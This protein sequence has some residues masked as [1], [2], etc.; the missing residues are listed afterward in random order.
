MEVSQVVVVDDVLSAEAVKLLRE[1]LATHTV[2]YE[3][4]M[5]ER[6]GGYARTTRILC[7]LFGVF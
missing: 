7:L 1:L 5:P 3:T 4:K 2:W 6:F